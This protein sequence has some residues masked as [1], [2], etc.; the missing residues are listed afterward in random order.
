MSYKFFQLLIPDTYIYLYTLPLFSSFLKAN[1]LFFHHLSLWFKFHS[2]SIHSP[3][4]YIFIK[5][6]L[7]ARMLEAVA[8]SKA[9]LL[10]PW[11]IMGAEHKEIKSINNCYGRNKGDYKK[12]GRNSKF[13]SL[14]F[15]WVV[16][17]GFSL[18]ALFKLRPKWT[19]E[20]SNESLGLGVEVVL[21]V[22]ETTK[23]EGV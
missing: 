3:T 20:A 8:A 9:N 6:V 23:L 10:C 14:N 21:E 11:E 19:E 13:Q 16:R 5:Y 15:D 12:R 1:Y 17:E 7:C 22:K 2:I 4:Q 18:E